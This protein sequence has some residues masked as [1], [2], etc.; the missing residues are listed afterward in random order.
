M[1]ATERAAAGG[2]S[3]EGF[4]DAP[5]GAHTTRFP[6]PAPDVRKRA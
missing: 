6:P 4:E 5:R 2:H 1:L 3:L